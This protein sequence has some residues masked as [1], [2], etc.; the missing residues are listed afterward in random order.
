MPGRR[1]QRNR[2]Q[3]RVN[4]SK[5]RVN[6][7][8]T[9]VN[10]KRINRRRKSMKGAGCVHNNKEVWNNPKNALVPRVTALDSSSSQSFGIRNM[11]PTIAVIW[12][13]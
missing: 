3:K 2:S 6:K 5:S 8:R 10:K 7:R 11:F 9:R 4:R 1:V 12:L 13:D